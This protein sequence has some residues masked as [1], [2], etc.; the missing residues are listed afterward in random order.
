MRKRSRRSRQ[1]WQPAGRRKRRRIPESRR[2][3][4]VAGHLLLK[5]N[6]RQSA[7][8]SRLLPQLH[9]CCHSFMA[10][11]PQLYG[12]TA[13]IRH[14][15]AA[16]LEVAFFIRSERRSGDPFSNTWHSGHRNHVKSVT[17]IRPSSNQVTSV[18]K[19]SDP[20]SSFAPPGHSK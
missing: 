13:T 14:Q 4:A 19:K 7:S 15:K 17:Q 6:I 12:R 20:V 9:G 5:Q 16:S 8:A 2:R 3:N 10:T 11:P 18:T 1:T